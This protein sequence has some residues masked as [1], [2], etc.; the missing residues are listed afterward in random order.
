MSVHVHSE[1]RIAPSAVLGPN[2][3]I[4][5]AVVEDDVILGAGVVIY[6]KV[7]IRRGV[8]IYDN[9]VLGR[10]PQVAGIIQRPPKADLTPLEIG[11][12]SVIGAN[13]VIYAGTSIGKNTLVGDLACIRE[14]CRIGNNVVL[15]RG[16][17]LNYNIEVQDWVR[18]MDSSHFGGD[19][20]IESD[21][22]IGP[23]VSSANDNTIGLA[24]QSVR[25]GA[26]IRRG[27]SVGVG[28]ILLANIEIG[29]QAIIGAGALVDS[30]IPAR[31]IAYGVPARVVRDVPDELLKPLHDMNGV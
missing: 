25:R 31:K 21:V 5:N 3:V 13:C 10:L 23:H 9:T 2:V 19:M 1:A 29:Q 8:H 11:A 12:D 17:M 28:V 16:V 20:V 30:N 14:E 22:F 18:I 15:G 24:T 26:Y 27:A 4:G 6:D 7:I